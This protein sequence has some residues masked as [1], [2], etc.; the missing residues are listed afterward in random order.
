M[1]FLK[2]LAACSLGGYM[3]CHVNDPRQSALYENA[4]IGAIARSYIEETILNEPSAFEYR[5]YA[6]EQVDFFR[7]FAQSMQVMHM[8]MDDDGLPDIVVL[9]RGHYGD[10]LFFPAYLTPEGV[11]Y[12]PMREDERYRD[13]DSRMKMNEKMRDITGE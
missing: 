4:V 6:P 5:T 1:K 2:T 12:R 7:K 9:N 3:L 8:D 13:R 10:G 11:K